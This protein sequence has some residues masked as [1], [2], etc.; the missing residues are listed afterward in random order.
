MA[1]TI[2][3]LTATGGGVS[4]GSAILKT[5]LDILMELVKHGVIKS[6]ELYEFTTKVGTIYRFTNHDDFIDWG[7]PSVRYMSIPLTRGQISFHLNL[8]AD[9]MEVR[10]A[11]I[12]A[13]LYEAALNDQ[14]DGITLSL[15][16]ALWDQNSASGMEYPLFAGTGTCKINR[17]EIVITFYSV[18]SSLNIIVPRNTFQQSC[19]YTLF[20]DGCT[21]VRADYREFSTTTSTAEDDYSVVDITFTLPVDDPKKYNNGEMVI[22]SGNCN[23]ERR[24]ILLTQDGK[25][26]VS[27]PFSSIIQVGT[28]FDFYPGC[29]YTPET[30]RDRWNNH[31]NFFGFVYLPP[32]EESL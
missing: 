1:A 26:I 13:E 16:Q 11:G 28:T 15:K 23:G 29:D 27:V 5:N 20:D 12:S 4:S 2:R 14:L 9:S 7:T 30:C 22:T 3:E 21:L 32:P 31:E 17:N 18:L 25:F 10:L 8:E 19:N 6:C 24:N